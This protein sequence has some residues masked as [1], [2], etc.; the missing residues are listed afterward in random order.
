[1]QPF[2]NKLLETY[3]Q[4]ASTYFYARKLHTQETSAKILLIC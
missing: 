1:M 4:L 2:E 3:L